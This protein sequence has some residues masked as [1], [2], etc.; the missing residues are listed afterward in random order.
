MITMLTYHSLISKTSNEGVIWRAQ[1]S[2][3][4][5]KGEDPTKCQHFIIV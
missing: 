1:M 2:N 3:L 5:I 4:Y